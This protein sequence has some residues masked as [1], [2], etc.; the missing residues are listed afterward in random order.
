M[1]NCY[2]CPIC[3]GP[4]TV[5]P[6]QTSTSSDGLASSSETSGSTG[7][8]TLN[9]GYCMW[10]SAEVGIEFDKPNNITAQ[11]ANTAAPLSKSGTGDAVS[12]QENSNGRNGSKPVDAFT[13]LRKFYYTQAQDNST[14][15]SQYGNGL[16]ISS[17]ANLTRIMGIYGSLGSGQ[18][19]KGESK[20]TTFREA[21]DANEGLSIFPGHEEDRINDIKRLGWDGMASK[22]QLLAQ[23]NS[24]ARFLTDLRPVPVTLRVKKAKRCR[25]CR[26]ILVKPEAKISTIRFK[27]RLTAPNYI[28]TITVLPLPT[29][30]QPP[31]PGKGLPVPKP[32][33]TLKENTPAQF[34]LEFKN[35]IYESIKVT[36]ATPPHTSG[37]RKTKITF[38]CPQFSVGA[39]GDVW[40]EA[41]GMSDSK[42][43]KGSLFASDDVA[44][45]SPVG[46][47]SSGTGGSEY[48]GKVFERGKNW[49]KVVVEVTP[50]ALPST[51][52]PEDEDGD[53]EDDALEIPVLVRVEWEAEANEGG[54]N[55]ALD[56]LDRDRSDKASRGTKERI[57]EQRV[58]RYWVVLGVGKITK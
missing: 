34:L 3:Q 48:L 24:E 7:K 16:G 2:L 46:K 23:P 12:K 17:P 28:P 43:R 33:V 42:G 52:K 9:C 57:L 22:E 29:A 15:S 25:A 14:R 31:P 8:W 40:D 30:P 53:E 5:N 49:A 35:P 51:S 58:L 6:V 55:P 56:G 21:R 18:K 13:A 44:V 45:S 41:L 50:G 1:R 36:L 32:S 54:R 37:K 4:T 38:F 39:N 10:S 27:I 20:K 47:S 19:P 11:L 26:H